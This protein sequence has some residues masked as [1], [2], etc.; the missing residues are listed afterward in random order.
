MFRRVLVGVDGRHGGRDAIALATALAAPDAVITLAHIRGPDLAIGGACSMAVT[1]GRADAEVL[2]ERE[3]DG[4]SLDAQ[5]VVLPDQ[6]VGHGLHVLAERLRAD[7]LV[8]GSTNHGLL[9]RALIDEDIRA[10][11]TGA[12]CAVAIASRGYRHPPHPLDTLGGH[13]GAPKSEL[14]LV[15]ARTGA[16]IWSLRV[17]SLEDMRDETP[18]QEDWRDGTTQLIDQTIERLS[19]LGDDIEADAVYGGPREELLRFGENLDV[20]LVGSHGD[21]PLGRLVDGG[22]A[23]DLAR[24]APRPLLILPRDSGQLHL[25]SVANRAEVTAGARE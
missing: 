4:A 15:A 22:M 10:V 18:T 14:A 16:T 13:D 7:L 8:I 1:A 20:L 17:A 12:S 23:D 3:R 19:E 24:D 5:L 25:T 11:L 21:G 2:L 6:R 9:G